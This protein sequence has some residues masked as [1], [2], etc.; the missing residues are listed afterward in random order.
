[1]T[2]AIVSNFKRQLFA[3]LTF[4]V[5]YL[6][7]F[8]GWAQGIKF[9]H[10]TSNDLSGFG[11]V[12]AVAEDVDGFLWFGT[13][14][15][16]YKYDGYDITPYQH[17]PSDSGSIS[18]NFVVS[19]FE[20]SHHNLW[21][22]TYGDGLDLY[23]RSKN[24][25]HHFRHDPKNN[26]SIPNDRVKTITETHDGT[27]WI[28]TEGGGIATLKTGTPIHVDNLNFRRPAPDSISAGSLFIRAIVEDKKT[29]VLYI[30]TFDRGISIIDPVRKTI[31]N[32]RHEP[33]NPNSL[34]SDKI[35]ELFLDS[36]NRLWIG[37]TDDGLDLYLPDQ[38]TITHY[39][40][41]ND[42][43]SVC[44]QEIET[45][46]EDATGR[47]WI[48]TDS[49]ISIMSDSNK[50]PRNYFENY[51]HQPLD[52]FS[53][54]SNSVKILFRDSR[55]SIWAG[56]YF[57]GMNVYNP[58]AFK[59]NALRSKPW[60][61]KSLSNNN[62]T[63]FAEDKNGNL[64]I[65]TDGGGLNFLPN[66]LSNIQKDDYQHI[67]IRNPLT[68]KLE[69]KVKSVVVDKNNFIWI[70]LWG[71]GMYRLDPSSNK[72]TYLAL[73]PNSVFHGT[74]VLQIEVDRKNNLWIGTFGDGIFYYDQQT[75]AL[76][77][78]QT[79]PNKENAL[80]SERIRT[81]LLDSK[82]RLWIGGDVG[83]LNLFNEATKSFERIE[84]QG[85]LTRNI[86]ILNLME[87]HDGKIWI[88]TV[89]SGAI[90]YDP[91]TKK[92]SSV[93]HDSA[94]INQVINAMLEDEHG[95]IW[96]STSSGIRVYDPVTNQS[97]IYTKDDGLQ[98]N[99]FNVNSALKAS[100]G[101]LMF[102]GISGW[103]AFF[104]DSIQVGKQ[105]P[106]IVF[107][108]L[109]VN[110]KRVNV[111]TPHSPLRTSITETKSIELHHYENSFSIEFAALEYNFSRKARYAYQLE[112][113]NDQWQYINY[114]RKITFTNLDPGRY[115]LRI[116]AKNQDGVWTEK[117][118]PLVIVIRP[119]WWQS[120]AF[121][122]SAALAV[123]IV[124]YTIF[125]LR[126]AYLIRQRKN[127]TREI[128]LHTAELKTKNNELAE[129]NGEILSQ[130][131]ELSAQNEQIITQREELELTHR[132]L[133]ETNEHLEELV[134][135]RT[136]KLEDT[137]RKLDKTV[138]ELDRFVYSASHDL[139]APLKSI[140]G[141]V[142]IAKMETD[143]A[144]V[145][146]YYNYIE[147]SI[148]KLERVIKN[149]VEF[150]RNSHLEIR[151]SPFKF[152]NLVG[153][154]MQ[155]L[156]FWPEARKVK[157]ID[158][159]DPSLELISD[160]QRLKVVLHNLI[161]NAIKY[162]DV[163]KNEP[164]IKIHCRQKGSSWLINIMDNGIGIDE[165]YQQKVFE[166]YYRATDRSQGSGLG[167]FIVREIVQ[168]LGGEITVESVR[169]QG[170][171]FLI[172]LPVI[173]LA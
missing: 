70:G 83:G 123:L 24:I 30:A 134:R 91:K 54:L 150:S 26:N 100:N 10:I 14:D 107:T 102:G 96:M 156:A 28:G 29:S 153:D 22:G 148:L 142:N 120:N 32:L 79:N 38:H 165:R 119:A 129:L 87:S 154:V 25:F 55:N 77:Q 128:E 138:A 125:R 43:H 3:S 4:T 73:D 7:G 78:Y 76:T 140:L 74:S 94:S 61:T 106:K 97:T 114:E 116:K 104:P 53:I 75:K 89:S 143:Q 136:E 135:H 145:G 137:V 95:K 42:L 170:T 130:N 56:T 146:H 172:E 167:L 50:I 161:G 86:T 67:P 58:R 166:M 19:L 160:E 108:D 110:N 157:I 141:L 85:V 90:V 169:G 65:G 84:Y 59:F 121:R 1:M 60:I 31:Q 35:L 37:T 12:W 52:E 173:K 45:I 39:P 81:M 82:G 27:L 105:L 99:H 151:L 168:K 5:L 109:W 155:E 8:H 132:K 72:T 68:G 41:A 80:T 44:D 33:G 149:L 117:A 127:L 171:E 126:L 15:G 152:S 113:F 66:A 18:G 131:E 112:P 103:N 124:F 93:L 64:W 164:Y 9:Q 57:G 147:M 111:H 21:I 98:S 101:M 36:R 122:V 144:Q 40:P 88:G 48:G 163:T 71:E 162:A 34:A 46:V 11:N 16:L 118:M 17:N 23:D 158:T 6:A 69:T 139:S 20:D 13:E 63:S 133:E 51:Q 47:I 49:G 2:R 159:S 115:T 62:V 92:A